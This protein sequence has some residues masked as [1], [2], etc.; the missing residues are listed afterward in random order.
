MCN[1]SGLDCSVPETSRLIQ[2]FKDDFE[3]PIKT[4]E[5]FSLS[6]LNR[7]HSK[8]D[9]LRGGIIGHGGCGALGPFGFGRNV[10]FNS[11]GKRRLRTVEMDLRRGRYL[12]I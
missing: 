11:C 10:Y 9:S 1:F 5:Q 7:S 3:I 2:N 8:W 4:K 12:L 6:S